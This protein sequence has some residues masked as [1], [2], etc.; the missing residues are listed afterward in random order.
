MGKRRERRGREGE[1]KSWSK[2]TKERREVGEEIPDS[3]IVWGRTGLVERGFAGIE[4]LEDEEWIMFVD[5]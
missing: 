1:R 4:D 2:R 3:E 5:V